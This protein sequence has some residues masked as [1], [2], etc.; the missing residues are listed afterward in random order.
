MMKLYLVVWLMLWC[1]EVFA[2]RRLVVASLE[3]KVPQRDIKVRIDNGDEIVTPWNGEFEVPDTFRRIA[4]S[5]PKFQ[6]RYVLHDE[7]KSDTIFLIPTFHAVDEVV[8]YGTD[9]SKQ[10][11]ANIMRPATPKEPELPQFV[12]PGPDVIALLMW[13]W[14][15]TFGPKVE[16][17]H[18]RKQALKVVRQKEQEYE[19]K[20]DALKAPQ[21]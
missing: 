10:M 20:W 15:H 16:A 13:T 8:V 17:R 14:E 3:S 12:P 7:V 6:H 9:R 11:M 21:K 4:F 19:R 2:Q 18:R 1:S 5:H